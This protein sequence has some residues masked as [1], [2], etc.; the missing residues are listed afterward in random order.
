MIRGKKADTLDSETRKNLSETYKKL[1]L[2][3]DYD[4]DNGFL[5]GFRDKTLTSVLINAK[6]KMLWKYILRTFDERKFISPC[7]AGSLFGI[8]YQNGDVF[9]CELLDSNIGNLKDFDFNFM[10]AWQSLKAK[11]IRKEIL[12]SKCFCTFECSWLSNIF[13]SPVYYPEILYNIIKN[14]K[15]KKHG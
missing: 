7:S 13:S 5:D 15:R 14:M 11:E 1:Q 8:I 3:S 2:Q 4:F 6:N 10:K 9:P 12:C